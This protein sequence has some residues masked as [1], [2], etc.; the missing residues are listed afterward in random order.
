[1]LLFFVSLI[2]RLIILRWPRPKAMD[3]VESEKKEQ[4]RRGSEEGGYAK[5]SGNQAPQLALKHLNLTSLSMLTS[6]SF[7][8]HA[9]IGLPS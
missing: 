7:S 6:T 8:F 5:Q 1:M 2:L 3:E 4:Q 9:I